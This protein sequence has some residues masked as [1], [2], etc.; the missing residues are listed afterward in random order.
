MA[1][2]EYG[3]LRV[4]EPHP[5]AKFALEYIRTIHLTTLLQY[6]EAM[7]SCSIE[8]NR[9]A[10]ICG[11]TLS[12]VLNGKPVSDRYVL[13]LAWYLKMLQEKELDE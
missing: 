9:I 2:D 1:E 6:R 5:M 4:G 7:A 8:G 10:E 13:G 11:S 12:R 3:T